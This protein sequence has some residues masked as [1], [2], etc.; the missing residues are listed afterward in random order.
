[1]AGAATPEHPL[2]GIHQPNRQI[3]GIGEGLSLN[4][5]DR[6]G[7][8]SVIMIDAA[9]RRDFQW[10]F[11]TVS[12]SSPRIAGWRGRLIWGAGWGGRHGEV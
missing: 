7:E 3:S 2:I 11:P 6:M 4:P 8:K 5:L 9:H 12:V 10:S 1:M